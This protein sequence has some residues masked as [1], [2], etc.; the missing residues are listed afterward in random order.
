MMTPTHTTCGTAAK[1]GLYAERMD[2]EEFGLW[3]DALYSAWEGYGSAMFCSE[4]GLFFCDWLEDMT[5]EYW[6]S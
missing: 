6:G 2:A 1:T 4:G 3:W 5:V